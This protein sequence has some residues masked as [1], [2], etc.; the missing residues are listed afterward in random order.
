MYSMRAAILTFPSIIRSDALLT[1]SMESS[2]ALGRP[3]RHL[4][5]VIMRR[6]ILCPISV[7]SLSY[8]LGLPF[9]GND[10]VYPTKASKETSN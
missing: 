10:S 8:T 9:S 4:P 5:H 2:G 1:P 3:T 7:P 6:S